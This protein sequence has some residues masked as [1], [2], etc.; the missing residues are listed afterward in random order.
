MGYTAKLGVFT[1]FLPA[2]GAGYSFWGDKRFGMN[3]MSLV[4]IFGVSRT[5]HMERRYYIYIVY[6]F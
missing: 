3:L 2:F 1:S 5:L 4:S 6:R